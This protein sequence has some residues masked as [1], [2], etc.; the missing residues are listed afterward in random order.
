MRT[1]RGRI[2]AAAN[3]RRA[4]VNRMR[5]LQLLPSER[6]GVAYRSE[7][8]YLAVCESRWQTTVLGDALAGY[9]GERRSAAILGERTPTSTDGK[10]TEVSVQRYRHL[11]TGVVP[12]NRSPRVSN[13]QNGPLNAARQRCV[14]RRGSLAR[15]RGEAKSSLSRKAGAVMGHIRHQ[16][17]GV[18]PTNSHG[19][20]SVMTRL[21]TKRKL[22]CTSQQ[23][24]TAK[25]GGTRVRAAPNSLAREGG[26]RVAAAHLVSTQERSRSVG[27]ENADAKGMRRDGWSSHLVS[28]TNSWPPSRRVSNNGH[29]H[30]QEIR[31]RMRNASPVQGNQ[32]HGALTGTGV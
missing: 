13:S 20:H 30:M 19:S 3:A 14:G 27:R 10:E 25:A 2:G 23:R 11:R 22:H 21:E 15:L 4:T 28:D 12:R 26:R 7:V 17:G 5:M 24:V 31:T 32:A 29:S 8:S 18:K 9:S 6:G 16:R 1:A